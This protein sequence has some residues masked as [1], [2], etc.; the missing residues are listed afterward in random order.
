M[1]FKSFFLLLYLASPC[2]HEGTKY[3]LQNF[4]LKGSNSY[5]W[6]IL[7]CSL[8]TGSNSMLLAH[9]LTL[10]AGKFFLHPHGF[11][12]HPYG[13][14]ENTVLSLR[15]KNP[16]TPPLH[17]LNRSLFLYVFLFSCW[18]RLHPCTFCHCSIWNVFLNWRSILW[19][20]IYF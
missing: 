8:K 7:I 9:F 16:P 20:G 18:R 13:R 12:L 15:R 19:T 1:F 11:I 4:I 3:M 5:S 14:T 17:L 2:T 6:R 10:F